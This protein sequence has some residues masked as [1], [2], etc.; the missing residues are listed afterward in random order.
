MRHLRLM[1][2]SVFNDD[3]LGWKSEVVGQRIFRAFLSG[4][5]VPLKLEKAGGTSREEHY[6]AR[7]I[8]Q[9]LERN[10]STQALV[11]VDKPLFNGRVLP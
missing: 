1:R 4:Q 5:R 9:S 10:A 8:N 11:N 7:L 2:L 3:V 6:P